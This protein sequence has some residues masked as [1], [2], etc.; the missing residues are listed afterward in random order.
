MR[1]AYVE[2]NAINL[3]L[4]QR[5]AMMGRH[6]IVNYTEGEV[7]LSELSK[8]RFD[9]ILMDVELAGDMNGL[10][11]VRAL[12][13]G[14][15]QTPIVAVTAYAMMGDREKCLEAGCTEYLPKP[16]PIADLL[17]LLARY[18]AQTAATA[19]AV[20]APAPPVIAVPAPVPAVSIVEPQ[21][22]PVSSNARAVG[23][24]PLK[25][26]ETAAAPT[27]PLTALPKPE[28]PAAPATPEPANAAPV[29]TA[30]PVIPEIP[31]IPTVP[32]SPAAPAAAVPVSAVPTLPPVDAE[33]KAPSPTIITPEPLQETPQKS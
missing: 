9:L 2:D 7:A 8:E 20:V 11:V 5:V 22:D 30:I 16:I 3:S 14:G 24:G 28:V 18:E 25:A 4:V 17:A 31:K 29:T 26:V 15:L 12:R 1:I 32:A 19:T 10:Q 21:S 27:V 33:V 23:T 13:S 6:F